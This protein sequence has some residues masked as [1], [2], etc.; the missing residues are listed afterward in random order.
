MLV[1]ALIAE[2]ASHPEA[3]GRLGDPSVEALDEDVSDG[4]AGFDEMCC[5]PPRSP[6]SDA[7]VRPSERIGR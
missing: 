4:F 3:A 6:P 5:D 1:Q 7:R 2:A